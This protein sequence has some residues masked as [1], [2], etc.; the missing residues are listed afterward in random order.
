MVLTGFRA[1]GDVLE[2]APVLA[3]QGGPAFALAAQGPREGVAGAGAD[4]GFRRAG[5]LP[6]RDVNAGPAPS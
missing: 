6:D 1:G 2:S 4:I 5:G 3:E